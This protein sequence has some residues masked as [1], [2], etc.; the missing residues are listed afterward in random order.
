MSTVLRVIREVFRLDLVLTAVLAVLVTAPFGRILVSYHFL[1]TVS[2]AALIALVVM[3]ALARRPVVISIV[4]STVLLALYLVVFVFK[5]GPGKT[6]TGVTSTWSDLLTSTTPAVTS[7]SDIAAPVL[8]GWAATMVGCLLALKTRPSAAPVLPPLVVLVV[9]LAFAGTQSP[10]SFLYPAALVVL[11]LG[12]LL[13]RSQPPGVTRGRGG[14]RVR[15]AAIVFGASAVVAIALGTLVPIGSTQSRFDL[16]SHYTPPLNLSNQVTPL[17]QVTP[18]LQNTSTTPIFSVSFSNVPTG[19]TLALVPIAYLESYDGAVW[20]TSAPFALAGPDLPPGA[21]ASVPTATIRQTFHL[22]NYPS[23]FLPSL[24]GAQKITG[25]TVGFDRTT[26]TMVDPAGSGVTAAYTVESAVPQITSDS[27]KAAKT[28]TDPS[29][30]LLTLPPSN[31]PWPSQFLTFASKYG[32]GSTPLARLVAIENQM[33]SAKAFGYTTNAR[34]GHSLGVLS[35]FLSTSPGDTYSH[36][37]DSEQFAAA[38][39][40]LAR[41]EGFPSRVVVGYRLPVAIKPGDTQVVNVVAADMYS[42]VEVNV[43]GVGWVT[44]DPTNTTP[45]KAP[46]PQ[47][48]PPPPVAT[49][50]PNAPSHAASAAA[51]AAAAAA[52]RH[53]SHTKAVVIAV[54]AIL[55]GLPM[56]ILAAKKFRKRMRRER[57]TPADQIIGAWKETRDAMRDRHIRMP[58]A[59]TAL[60]MADRCAKADRIELGDR[61][62]SF[63]PLIDRA[64]YSIDGPTEEDVDTAWDIQDGVVDALKEG[65]DPASRLKGLRASFDPRT[66]VTKG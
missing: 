35:D 65:T 37:G 22:T 66:L 20:G 26:G 15:S 19:S 5:A 41:I 8:L 48:T 58:K 60:E 42:W 62:T 36:I 17:A 61:L 3:G 4:A 51:A 38:F 39:A 28:G 10:G 12:L 43:N 6:W 53:H 18:A 23:A 9:A 24:E 13:V 30:A 14:R 7:A 56:L 50:L 47:V 2:G 49:T 21:P 29:L 46:P 31:E 34:P 40:I 52:H 25:L 55:V 1:V 54:L 64:L 32:V 11:T 44:F 57:G 45:R 33:R 27:L 63:G 16:R 59:A